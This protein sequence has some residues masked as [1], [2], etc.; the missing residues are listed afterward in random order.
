MPQDPTPTGPT[1]DSER[2]EYLGGA[3]Q[4]LSAVVTVA[5]RTLFGRDQASQARWERFW[6]DAMGQFETD[7]NKESNFFEQGALG[8]FREFR[9]FQLSDVAD[10]QKA[11]SGRSQ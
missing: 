8:M 11:S 4:G 1:T 5:L 9:N 2:I 3:L 6:Q 7:H 10:D